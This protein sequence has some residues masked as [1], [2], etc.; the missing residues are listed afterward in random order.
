MALPELT[1][2]PEIEC[3]HCGLPVP[4]ALV[5]ADAGEQFC[6]AGCQRVFH[7]LAEHGFE[8]FYEL[9]DGERR[10]ARTTS[11]GYDELDDD[12]F[13]ARNSEPLGD[14]CRRTRLYLEGV[15]CTAC[16]WLVER[17]PRL[18]PGVREARLDLG[19]QMAEV[20]WDPEVVSLSRVARAI[21][22][23]G[24]PVHPYR[25]ADRLALRRRQERALLI[26]IAVAG[27]AAGNVM[28]I[29]AALYAGLFGAMGAEH[30]SLFRWASLVITV[31]AVVYAGQGF[32][33]GAFAA[34]RARTL[35]M[36]L[37][38]AIGLGA[39]AVWGAVNTV[40]G[41]GEI[42]FDSVTALIFLLLCGRW[43]QLRQQRKAAD[44]TELL[45]SLTP[46]T[47]RLVVGE[48]ERTVP[49]EALT[50]G[51]EVEVAAG[52]TVPVDGVITRGATAVDR[53]LLTGEHLPENVSVGDAVHAGTL[54]TAAPMRVR[55][56]A[57]G[58]ETRVGRLMHAIE[59]LARR[60]APIV[61]LADRIAGWFVA[62]ALAL[63]AVT[64]AAWWYLDATRAF[65][66]AV[67]LL[68]VT[69]PC[70]LGLATPLAVSVAIGRAARRGILVKGGDTI[71]RLA[72]PAVI[73][74]D[75]TGTLTRG[76]LVL[77]RWHGDAACLRR[78]AALEAHSVHP[79]GRALA[80]AGDGDAPIATG[81]EERFGVGI[82]GTVDGVRV[83]VV[84]PAAAGP[85]PMS[86]RARIDAIAD[87][88][89]TPV[90]VREDGAL[91]GVAGLRDQ[92]RPDATA[93]VE[94]LRHAGYRVKLLSGDD[95]RAVR[96]IGAELGIDESD[97]LGGATPENKLARVRHA[98]ARGR[99]I[100]IGDGVN[101]AA[102]LS[103][104]TC[105]IAV[106][107]SAEASLRSADVFI[108]RPD[109]AAV[110]ELIEGSRATLRVIRRNLGFSLGY[111][112]I[113]ASL[114]ITGLIH[115][116]IAAV[117]MPLSSITVIASSVRGGGFRRTP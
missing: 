80:A 117:M 105:G 14:G 81:V 107:G 66:N 40:R 51:D 2:R 65:D 15:H 36:D 52:E 26:K 59:E 47:A 100:M 27:A 8:R 68:I 28:L 72:Q 10:P 88:G 98:A 20:V 84:A 5:R 7:L 61:Q 16:V 76:E 23:L 89:G 39:G 34:L 110:V 71:E 91:A 102:A 95:P 93:T 46:G 37:P 3:A 70:A 116:L 92:L 90:V 38:I 101:D 94:R 21:D 114:A 22:D 75:K 45:Y 86:W 25:G 49:I 41:T 35:H 115:P 43:V 111:N 19:R 74:A 54:N 67:A 6:C 13:L 73:Y 55:A 17:V 1:A 58:D 85:M 104:A 31:P 103:A 63:A 24:Y 56:T 48:G 4:P 69:C 57:T 78:V 18:L 99:V 60:R 9:A 77:G 33:R 97:C 32:F 62:V 112:V 79:I 44:A 30:E 113:G 106:R 82:R 64:F 12:G 29:A 83:E 11:R 96:A 42:Y 87:A 108:D 53:A 109:L 50:V